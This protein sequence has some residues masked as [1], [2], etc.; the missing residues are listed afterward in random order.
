MSRKPIHFVIPAAGLGSRFKEAGFDVDKPFI[1][2][3]EIP[4]LIWAISNLAFEV[5]DLL[6]IVIREDMAVPTEVNNFLSKLNPNY[7]FVKMSKLS[8]GSAETVEIA[9]EDQP[10]DIP[11]IVVNSDQFLLSELTGFIDLVR[12]GDS[13]GQILTMNATGNKWSYVNRNEDGFI[14]EVREKIE[15]SNE[16]TVGIYG[17]SNTK[18]YLYSLGAMKNA[19]DLVNGEFYVAPTYNYLISEGKKIEALN[20]GNVSDKFFGL[21]TPEDL[22]LFLN[23]EFIQEKTFNIRSRLS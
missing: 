17:W 21:G 16:A 13:D 1:S 11:L 14:S 2:V 10:Q 9:L 3:N 7:R 4:M 22:R 15:I 19:G 8:G 12:V 20:I 23:Q 6:T 18:D 5:S